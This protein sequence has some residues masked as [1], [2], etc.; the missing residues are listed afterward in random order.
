MVGDGRAL[1]RSA[2]SSRRTTAE[3]RR[4]RSAFR[5]ALGR[6]PT[7]RGTDGAG[8]LRRAARPGERLPG[9]PEPERVRVR[10]LSIEADQPSTIDTSR[11]CQSV[12]FARELCVTAIA[13]T[14]SGSSAAA[15][16]ASR[17]RRCWAGRLL[18]ADSSG[19]DG[20]CIIRPKA[21]R[22]VQL[23]MAGAASHIDLFDYKPELVEAP[24]PAVATSASRSRRSRTA[25]ARGCKPLWDFKPYG[26]CGKLL[27]D[28][29]AP[30]GDVRRRHRLRPQHGRQDGRPQPGDAPADDRLST[31]RLSRHG[32]RGSATASAA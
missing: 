21:K 4:S 11:S 19:A 18:A 15:S 20:G 24:R 16:A 29:V 32:L 22:V 23:F 8:R 6:A 2:S 17:W 28:V 13:A 7:R 25:S 3:R 14:S 5:L 1:R 10:R 12:Q 26:Q 9:D 31:A 30:L 27:S